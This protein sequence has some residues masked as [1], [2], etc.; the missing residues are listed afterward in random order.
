MS[1]WRVF[2]WHSLVM[3]G[4]FET[5]NLYMLSC[6]EFYFN[7]IL[8]SLIVYFYWACVCTWIVLFMN[9]NCY[10]SYPCHHVPILKIT[11]TARREEFI[12]FKP[13][14]HVSNRSIAINWNKIFVPKVMRTVS[15][16]EKGPRDLK[17]LKILMNFAWFLYDFVRINSVAIDFK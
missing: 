9:I 2:Q 6:Y 11:V 10:F 5:T 1:F 7:G 3:E 15:W 16:N 17:W 14:G 8:Y 12:Q 13:Q 4:M